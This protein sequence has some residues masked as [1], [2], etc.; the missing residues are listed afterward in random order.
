MNVMNTA[1]RSQAGGFPHAALAALGALAAAFALAC[2]LAPAAFANITLEAPT[3]VYDDVTRLEV[4]KLEAGTHNYL[5]G[6]TLQVV[7]KDTGT[8]VDEWTTGTAA[9][10]ITRVLDVETVYV[11]KEKKAPKGY[12]TAGDVEFSLNEA[13]GSGIQIL[14]GDD[15]EQ[16]GDYGINLFN[17]KISK[18]VVHKKSTKSSDAGILP[19]TGDQ[20]TA[21]IV[22]ALVL[23]AAIAAG[24]IVFARRRARRD[25]DSE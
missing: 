24:V 9:H 5:E 7:E 18:K 1:T 21:W 15:A 22:G 8:V 23:V 14:S 3:A 4:S 19:R 20:V 12:D 25:E 2:C 17:T 6:A 13:A 16:A 10:E 11:L